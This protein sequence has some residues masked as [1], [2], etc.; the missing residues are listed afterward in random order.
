MRSA[1]VEALGNIG[2]AR[3]LPWM[4]YQSTRKDE[5]GPVAQ[6]AILKLNNGQSIDK[7]ADFLLRE[8]ATY[9]DREVHFVSNQ[10]ELWFWDNDQKK[11]LPV[12]L[13]KNVAEGAIG[14]RLA[15]MALDI[16][17]ADQKD[18]TDWVRRFRIRIH[19]E[20]GRWLWPLD[21]RL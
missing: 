12:T 7:P 18:L 15:K 2:D 16:D 17:P 4:V 1:M 10:I 14:Y 9:L 21:H 8:S 6:S 5:A 3:A 13:D 19:M 11:L 20:S